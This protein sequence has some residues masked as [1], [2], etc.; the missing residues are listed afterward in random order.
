MHTILTHAIAAFIGAGLYACGSRLWR[1]LTYRQ[2]TP[3]ELFADTWDAIRNQ[4]KDERWIRVKDK[5]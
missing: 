4:W 3:A 1:W 5:P 2:E